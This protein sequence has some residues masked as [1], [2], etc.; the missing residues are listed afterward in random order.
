MR[1]LRAAYSNG[2][3]CLPGAM[4]VNGTSSAL[5]TFPFPSSSSSTSTIAVFVARRP[6]FV[7]VAAAALAPAS[8]ALAAAALDEPRVVRRGGMVCCARVLKEEEKK[9][10][11]KEE[12]N[13]FL[14]LAVEI[15]EC[16]FFFFLSS[17]FSLLFRPL[18]FFSLSHT[19]F[20]DLQK[21]FSSLFPFFFTVRNQP[22]SR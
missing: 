11:K 8:G 3:R 6:L 21:N 17:L 4:G 10:E 7:V 20:F 5:A 16:F 13:S 1:S 14:S 2:E 19:L 22:C 15:C 18:S 9:R 12:R